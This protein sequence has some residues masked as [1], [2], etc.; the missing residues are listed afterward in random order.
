MLSIKITEIKQNIESEK[1]KLLK[2]ENLINKIN[3]EDLNM[4]KYDVVIKKVDS[5]KVASI[6]S[7][8]PNYE[9]QHN[10]WKELASVHQMACVVYKGSY[11][12]LPSAYAALEK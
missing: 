6:R 2:L 7:I 9:T 10:V 1:E 5:L 8:L 12:S 3:E 11:Q 4:L